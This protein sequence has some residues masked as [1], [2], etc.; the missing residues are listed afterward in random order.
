MRFSMCWN[1]FLR[2]GEHWSYHWTQK[3]SSQLIIIILQISRWS[4]LDSIQAN[5]IG[6]SLFKQWDF[7]TLKDISCN[8]DDHYNDVIMSTMASQITSLTIVYSTFY[9][10][11][12]WKK[13]SKLHDNS[14]MIGE[15]PTQRAS[16][17]ENISIWWHHHV[18]QQRLW[19]SF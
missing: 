3:D 17:M 11:R 9:S 6:Q 10:R 12:R 15:F 13:T 2:N 16:N 5:L 4:I 1:W 8:C 7:D 14:P 18:I 19:V